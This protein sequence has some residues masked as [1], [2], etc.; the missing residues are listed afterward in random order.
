[1]NL[2]ARRE[3]AVKELQGRLC[4]KWRGVEGIRELA[5]ELVADLEDEGVLS[6]QRYAAAFV[7][8]RQQRSQGPVKIRAELRQR[9]LPDS[10]IEEALHQDSAYWIDLAANWLLRQHGR[11]FEF[12]DRARFYRRLVSRGFSHEQAMG[13]LGQHADGCENDPSDL[14]SG[15]HSS[16]NQGL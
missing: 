15:E 7:R 4:V 2:L 9:Q 16:K 10:L 8:S 14:N 1:M 6:D 3:Y 11:E 13:A 12:E 5:D